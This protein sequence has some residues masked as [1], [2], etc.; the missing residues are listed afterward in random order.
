MYRGIVRTVELC[1]V[2]RKPRTEAHEVRHLTKQ[3]EIGKLST[4][5]IADRST[6]EVYLSEMEAKRSLG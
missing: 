1:M 2:E 3:V 4:L 5:T 6:K